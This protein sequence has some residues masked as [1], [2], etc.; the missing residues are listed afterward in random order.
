MSW[1]I[2]V[3]SQSWIPTTNVWRERTTLYGPYLTYEGASAEVRDA[4][5]HHRE[6][7]EVEPLHVVATVEAPSAAQ[8]AEIITHR[9]RPYV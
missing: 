2:T 1:R 9:F 3:T 6:T 8:V 4:V 5:A 7:A